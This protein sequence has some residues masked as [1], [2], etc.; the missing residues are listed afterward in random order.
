MNHRFGHVMLMHTAL[1]VDDCARVAML[2][3]CSPKRRV[4]SGRLLLRWRDIHKSWKWSAGL[5]MTQTDWCVLCMSWRHL[6]RKLEKS[7]HNYCFVS[8][9]LAYVL[10]I[11]YQ[12]TLSKPGCRSLLKTTR[13]SHYLHF[14]RPPIK[15]CA[16]SQR[17]K[18][19]SYILC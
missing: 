19:L 3:F 15:L 4:V 11:L 14:S 12:Q 16:V 8:I 13:V 6:F 17:N 18:P 10:L 2:V 7:A 9:T 1:A 5:K